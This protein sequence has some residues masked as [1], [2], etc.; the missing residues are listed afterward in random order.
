MLHLLL[1]ISVMRHIANLRTF[2]SITSNHQKWIDR[3]VNFDTLKLAGHQIRKTNIKQVR[4]ASVYTFTLESFTMFYGLIHIFDESEKR[5][6]TLPLV[7]ENYHYKMY[8]S[9]T[10]HSNEWWTTFRF[11]REWP[12]QNVK[13]IPSIQKVTEGNLNLV[14]YINMVWCYEK[15]AK[16]DNKCVYF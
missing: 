10:M 8:H 12:K 7:R 14:N 3:G 16:T 5:P 15:R 9:R 1:E 11:Q 6:Q 2:Q 4:Y 13:N